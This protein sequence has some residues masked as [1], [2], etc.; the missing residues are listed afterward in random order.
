MS[1][2]RPSDQT[3]A[4]GKSPKHSYNAPINMDR[5]KKPSWSSKR[6]LRLRKTLQK[7]IDRGT[8]G[9][10]ENFSI[11]CRPTMHVQASTL[12]AMKGPDLLRTGNKVPLTMTYGYKYRPWKPVVGRVNCCI[13][14]EPCEPR[15]V[16]TSAQ[17]LC[18]MLPVASEAL[19]G[20]IL[21]VAAIRLIEIGLAVSGS[22]VKHIC[23]TVYTSHP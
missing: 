7:T 20:L 22:A 16:E 11:L 4:F 17:G 12:V 18:D 9:P 15:A 8:H 3:R 13:I 5:I 19:V 10:V 6:N 23:P 1:W 21:A 14:R 2:S